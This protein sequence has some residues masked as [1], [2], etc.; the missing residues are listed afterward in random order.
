MTLRLI[1][2][3]CRFIVSP[4]PTV[5]TSA[6]P[7][8]TR[9]TDGSEQIGPVVAL[10]ARRPRPGAALGPHAGQRALLADTGFILPPELDRLA[11]RVRRDG[12]DDQIGKVFLCACWIAASCSG[13]RGRTEI[14]R[15]P[16]R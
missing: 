4:S 15:K 7:A 3:R 16:R 11:A 14:R 10:I 2:A 6:A 13:Q 9:R 1:S 12:S 8:V 5:R